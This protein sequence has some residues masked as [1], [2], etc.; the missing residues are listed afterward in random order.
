LPGD[1]LQHL[2]G[3]LL[4]DAADHRFPFLDD[5]ALLEGDPSQGR[6]QALGMVVVDGNDD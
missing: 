6:A 5:A 2:A 3:L 1:F 4:V